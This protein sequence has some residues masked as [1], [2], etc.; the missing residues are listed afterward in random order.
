MNKKKK[1]AAISIM[2]SCGCNLS[3]SYCQIAQA[4]NAC[5]P[6]LQ[7]K[8]I[9]ALKNGE[10]LE[11]VKKSLDILEVPYSD[12]EAMSLWGQEPTL[13]LEHVTDHLEDWFTTFPNISNI[14][15]STNGMDHKEKLIDFIK[16]LNFIV[17]KPL[18][19]TLQM[20]WDGHESNDEIRKG[21]S[22]VIEETIEYVVSE[23]NHIFI[24]PILT[25]D[26][27]I[28]NVISMELCKRLNTAEK[29][30]EYYKEIRDY[31]IKINHL[32][33]NRQVN[34]RLPVGPAAENPV[35]AAA[36]DGI[37]FADFCK[38]A[39]RIGVRPDI[40]GPFTVPAAM[41]II[42]NS[43]QILESE[44]KSSKY[45]S[46][47]ECIEDVEK[48]PD[49]FFHFLEQINSGMYCSAYD[50]ELKFM[51]DGTML[52]CQNLIFDTNYDNI[53][54]EKTLKNDIKRA[55]AQKKHYINLLKGDTVEDFEKIIEYFHTVRRNAFMYLMHQTA[56]LMHWMSKVDQIDI[57]Y[58]NNLP[59]ILRHAFLIT[60][61]HTCVF[62]NLTTAGSAFN[63]HTGTI[64]F[65]CNG[66]LD[67][68]E[69]YIRV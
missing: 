56:M 17:T 21:D 13:T 26:I 47:N 52:E 18:S 15:F 28:H 27:P 14:M 64:R 29:V 37:L 68:F 32:N 11:N 25:I 46:I 8:T 20:S 50:G 54:K 31:S 66:F 60:K 23:L 3:C 2:S 7:K 67:L 22:S 10:F 40:V 62:N 5:T 39:L 33:I 61:L 12:I 53:L 48:N 35:N 65:Y 51:Y 45:T 19:F 41:L 69:S 55:L 42:N 24:K 16:K 30:E 1:V 38:R 58:K 44:F 59:K 57:S 9:E 49:E 34:V 63:R 6:E 4:A 36:E 43:A